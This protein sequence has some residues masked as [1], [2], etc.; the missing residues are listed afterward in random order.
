MGNIQS[1]VSS[2]VCLPSSDFPRRVKIP[3]SDNVLDSRDSSANVSFILCLLK[4][5]RLTMTH[6][7]LF[8][9]IRR[10]T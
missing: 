9:P 2:F 8:I 7:S 6:I 5:A 3:D 4:E 1:T 10:K